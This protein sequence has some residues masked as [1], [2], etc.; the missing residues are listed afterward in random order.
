L[1]TPAQ[2]TTPAAE[3]RPQERDRRRDLIVL[4]A[5]AAQ[6]SPLHRLHSPLAGPAA[7]LPRLD[8]ALCNATADQRGTTGAF[9][10]L[11]GLTRPVP[12]ARPQPR[13]LRL[14]SAS[15]HQQRR[16]RR[17]RPASRSA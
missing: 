2:T 17:Q 5:A 14:A 3:A 9:T 16:S 7:R 1:Q 12:R 6:A 11:L 15:R 10:L 8:Y 4:F 13:L